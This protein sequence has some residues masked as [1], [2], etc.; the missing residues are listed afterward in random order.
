M[1]IN[2]GR[3]CAS[4]ILHLCSCRI[5]QRVCNR[6]KLP[7]KLGGNVGTNVGGGRSGVQPVHSLEFLPKAA[8]CTLQKSHGCKLQNAECKVQQSVRTNT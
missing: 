5:A 6:Q 7:Q 8:E 2:G 4:F 3:V 1:W